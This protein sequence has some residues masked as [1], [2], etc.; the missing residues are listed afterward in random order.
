MASKENPINR[1]AAE[2]TKEL[3]TE[4]EPFDRAASEVSPHI[5]V[6]SKFL[7]WYASPLFQLVLVALICFLCPGMF[8]AL[9]GMGGGGM[10]DATLVDKMV[11]SCT[12]SVLL[13]YSHTNRQ[14][15]RTLLY[16]LPLHSL[17]SF[18]VRL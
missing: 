17:V 10:T 5:T 2:T 11:K 6:Y 15:H 18:Q 8:N 9:S 16:M 7:G 3:A 4:S 13:N 12:L 14:S 1:M